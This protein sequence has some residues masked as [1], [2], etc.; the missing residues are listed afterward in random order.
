MRT[1]EFR[2]LGMMDYAE[3]WQLQEQLFQSVIDRKLSNRNAA[4]DS[5]VPQR[6]YLLFCE[7]PPVYTLGRSGDEKNLLIGAE[8]LSKIGATYY[9]NNRG[10]DIT[11]HGPGQI[12]GY[13]ILDLD[14]FF[15]DIHRYLRLLEEAVILTIA[16]YGLK[17]DRYPGYTGVWLDPRDPQRARKIC[18]LGVRCSRWVTMHG[19][20]FNVNT[21]LNYFKNIVPCGIEDKAVT[22]MAQE[23]GRKIAMEEVEEKLKRH[24]AAL[25]EMQ[26]IDAAG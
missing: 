16:E 5:K 18:A 1:V 14:E 7:H 24:I 6:H 20:A 4:D 12:V 21:D 11:F 9:K 22:S 25:F 13:P 15:T 10:G 2:D 17:G 19:F 26:L 23:L 3:A 8:E